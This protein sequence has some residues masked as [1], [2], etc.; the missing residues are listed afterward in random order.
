VNAA[1]ATYAVFPIA[2]KLHLIRPYTDS[3][4]MI[5]K[6]GCVAGT[7]YT[8]EPRHQGFSNLGIND[9][10]FK[11]ATAHS[12]D[13]VGKATIWQVVGLGCESHHE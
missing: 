4:A 10:I 3:A 6:T 11:W 8:F 9:E 13:L 1:P 5:R 12:C 2:V 7:A